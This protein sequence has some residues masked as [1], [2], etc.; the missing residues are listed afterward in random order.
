MTLTLT[1][2]LETMPLWR[3]FILFILLRTRRTEVTA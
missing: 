2:D 1:A 3:L